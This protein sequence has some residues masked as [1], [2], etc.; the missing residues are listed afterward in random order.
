M[1]AVIF[2]IPIDLAESLVMAGA[3]T[4][5]VE[6]GTFLGDT[7]IALRNLVPNVWSV[8]L[9]DSMYRQAQAHVGKREGIEL[10][11][12]YSPEVLERLASEVTGPTLFWLDAHGKTDGVPDVP[13]GCLECPVLDEIAAIAKFPRAEDSCILVDDARALFGPMLHHNPAEW[14]TFT[15]VSDA[16]RSIGDRYVTVLDDIVIAVPSS[17][18]PVVDGWWRTKLRERHGYEAMQ[19]RI[20][21]L[22]D[23]S[24]VEASLRLARSLLPAEP[25]ERLSKWLARRGVKAPPPR[26]SYIGSDG[27]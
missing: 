25:R 10:L 27:D 6:T 21:Q 14:P 12:G 2:G 1:G 19:D 5:A 3:L 15:E 20:L 9:I 11:L 18:R 26:R 16:L 13:S 23:P 17:L 8:E 4:A 7:A 24:P 22:S